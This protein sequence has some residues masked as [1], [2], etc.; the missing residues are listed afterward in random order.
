MKVTLGLRKSTPIATRYSMLGWLSIKDQI[1]VQ[2]F[3]ILTKIETLRKDHML[4][5]EIN[6]DQVLKA[7]KDKDQPQPTCTKI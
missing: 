5:K 6:I 4:T 3:K 2:Y 7:I 1:F